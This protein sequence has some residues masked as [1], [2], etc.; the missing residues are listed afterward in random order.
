[1]PALRNHNVL[2]EDDGKTVVFMHRI[3]PGSA[4]KSYGIHVAQLAGVPVEVLDRAKS[5]LAELEGRHVGLKGRPA[6]KRQ[7]PQEQQGSLFD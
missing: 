7:G 5:V 1:L 4:D 6:R 3:A 2:V